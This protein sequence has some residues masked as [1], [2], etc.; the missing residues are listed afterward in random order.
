MT[1]AQ[2]IS[3]ARQA[4]AATGLRRRLDLYMELAKA[5]LSALVVLTALT[6]YLLAYTAPLNWGHLLLTLIGTTLAAWSAN[7]LNQW[8]EADRD[9]R[10]KRTCNRPLPSGRIQPGAAL[11]FALVCGVGGVGLLG[12]ATNILTAGL[13]LITI[14]IYV[15]IYTPLKTRSTLNT[16][17]GAIC[18]AIP[19]MMGWSAAAGRLDAGAWVLGAALFVW[20]MPHFL[21]LAWM[22]RQD[23]ARAGYRMLPLVDQSG[24]LT[25]GAAVLYSLALLPIGVVMSMVGTTGLLAAAASLALGGW[26]VWLAVRFAATRQVADARRLFLASV[27]YLPLVMGVMVIDRQLT[28]SARPGAQANMVMVGDSPGGHVP[29]NPAATKPLLP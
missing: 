3:L 26:L 25:G 17:V 29:V 12:L 19:P 11:G 28:E 5:R 21:A 18:G 23:Y 8:A 9:A 27:I 4:S 10:M 15:L 7:A 24:R 16:V 2:T 6:G 22:Y 14:L 20:Q 13:G 1:R